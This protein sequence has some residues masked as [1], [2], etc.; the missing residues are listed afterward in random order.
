MSAL[1]IRAR[2]ISARHM[3]MR[4][5][6]DMRISQRSIMLQCET[7]IYVAVQSSNGALHSLRCNM[8]VGARRKPLELIGP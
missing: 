4:E 3:N 7:L 8:P 1:Y 5:Y 6:K 2:F